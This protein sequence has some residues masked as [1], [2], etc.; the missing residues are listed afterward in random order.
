MN[1]FL[2]PLR[3]HSSYKFKTEPRKIYQRISAEQTGSENVPDYQRCLF[4]RQKS[5]KP[6]GSKEKK[7]LYKLE[8]AATIED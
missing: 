3:I 2:E 7:G 6:L 8:H 5:A 4:W 1:I